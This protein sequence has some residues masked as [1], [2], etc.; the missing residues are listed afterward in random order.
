MLI[1]GPDPPTGMTLK[2]TSPSSV[3]VTWDD[4]VADSFTLH[5]HLQITYLVIRDITGTNYTFTG[6]PDYLYYRF[7]MSA[8]FDR[9]S[10]VLQSPYSHDVVIKEGC[11]LPNLSEYSIRSTF[12]TKLSQSII[13]LP[14]F[15]CL[16]LL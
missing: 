6:L 4:Q 15:L 12:M 8:Q 14:H 5:L 16:F 2:L 13:L 11:K 3:L 9:P 7:H 1:T 10:G